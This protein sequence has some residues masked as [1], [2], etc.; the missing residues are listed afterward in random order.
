M[1]RIRVF[2]FG[3]VCGLLMTLNLS[4][5][6]GQFVGKVHDATGAVIEGAS[7]TVTNAATSVNRSVITSQ[8]GAFTM[9][10]LSPGP[11]E[12]TGKKDGFRR[13]VRSNL[14]LTIGESAD[15]DLTREGG[16][17]NDSVTISAETSLVQSD[18]AAVG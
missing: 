16:Q 12:L 3:I 9:P 5:Q 4:A 17:V 7:I 10:S 11:Y 15:L 8:A 18:N 6:T 14:V 2:F 1:H 13:L